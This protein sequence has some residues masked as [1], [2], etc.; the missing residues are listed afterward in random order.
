MQDNCVFCKIISGK[1]SEKFVYKSANV[2]VFPDID[3]KAPLHLLIIPAKHISQF[4][5]I[6]DHDKP[7]WDEMIK[8]VHAQIDKHDLKTKGY[9]IVMNG[10]PAAMIDHLHIHLL[11]EI[12]KERTV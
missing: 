10:G 3:P 5:E 1:I 6:S 8:A 11:G 4:A 12:G 2:A 9:R 7:I